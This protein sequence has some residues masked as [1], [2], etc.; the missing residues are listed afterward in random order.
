[1]K[2]S[3]KVDIV[4]RGLSIDQYSLRIRKMIDF[5]VRYQDLISSEESGHVELHFHKQEL[6]GKV[7]LVF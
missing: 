5:L 7:T 4:Q 6:K 2:S 1:M 3:A